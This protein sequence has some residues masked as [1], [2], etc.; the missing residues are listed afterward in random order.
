M[1]RAALLLAAS[2]AGSDAY[3]VRPLRSPRLAPALSVGRAPAASPTAPRAP[4]A[5]LLFGRAQPEEPVAL[6]SSRLVAVGWFS[7]WA[8]AILSTVAGV[9]LLFANSVTNAPT[10]ITLVG[11]ALALGGLAAALAST[12]WTVR[13]SRL[14]RSFGRKAVPPGQAAGDAAS[15]VK[16]GV[17]LNVVGMT[18]CLLAAEAIVGTLA[19]KALTQSGTAALGAVANPVQALDVLIVQANTN[20]IAAH[21]VSLVANM[22]LRGAATSCAAAS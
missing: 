1:M 5:A 16:V 9:L 4:A 7:W 11:R 22:R 21:F 2:L 8:Q 20:T 19:A 14:A 12:I 10:A 3:T 6:L 13:Y 15:A 17:A 18:L